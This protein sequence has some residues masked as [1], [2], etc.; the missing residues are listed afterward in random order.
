MIRRLVT[1]VFIAMLP[2]LVFAESAGSAVAKDGD[3]AEISQRQAVYLYNFVSYVEW[4]KLVFTG[5]TKNI[6]LCIIGKDT[7][8]YNIDKVAK[9]ALELSKVQ[10][11]IR[12]NAQGGDLSTC[13]IAYISKSEEASYAS[14]LASL[15]QHPVLTV[16]EIKGF[17]DNGGV[18]EFAIKRGKLGF[19]TNIKSA[20]EQNLKIG[21]ELL[22]ISF[23]VVK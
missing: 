23:E 15:K 19:K 22:E 5:E 7:L 1:L 8:G 16:S 9:K 14:T 10:I 12:R 11:N 18:I 4:P 2:C 17:A 21:S 3:E 20:K 13:N 6:D